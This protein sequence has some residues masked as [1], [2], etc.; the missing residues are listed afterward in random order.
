MSEQKKK[1]TSQILN[2]NS[3]DLEQ[4]NETRQSKWAGKRPMVLATKH[5]LTLYFNFFI[6][7]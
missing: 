5:W 3:N 4:K 2:I 7:H 1:D 6:T